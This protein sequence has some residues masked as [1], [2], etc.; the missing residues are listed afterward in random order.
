MGGNKSLD[1][2]KHVVVRTEADVVHARQSAREIA[3]Q[4]GFR[5]SELTILALVISELAR[6]ILQ[7]AGH[8][9][10]IVRELNSRELPS[11]EVIA[12]DEGPG[13]SDLSQAM[14]VG[15]STSGGLGLGLPGVKKLMDEFEIVSEPGRGTVV[16][17][18]KCR[19]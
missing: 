15:F 10:I 19:R 16:T 18:R 4:L 13:I 12:Q 1:A 14:R 17:A 2:E 5:S 8:G 11:V 9:E 7:Y 6:N 3:A